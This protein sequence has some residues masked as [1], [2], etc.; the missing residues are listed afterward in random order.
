MKRGSLAGPLLIILIGVWFLVAS[1]RPDLPTLEVAARFWPFLLIGWGV[2]RLVELLL[3]V[4]KRKPLPV[5]GISGGE[6]TLVV[7]IC[8]IGSGLYVAH[9]HQPW[10][11]LPF[12]RIN[13]LEMFGQ[14]Y[15]FSIPEQRAA[16][17]KVSRILVENFRGNTRIVGGDVQEVTVAGRKSVRALSDKDAEA[18]NQQ[19]Q[20]EVTAQADQV[21]VRTNQERVTGEQRVSSDLDIT[22]PRNAAIEVRGR[23]GD[24]ELSGINGRV[25]LSSDSGDVR[26]QNLGGDVRV[27]VRKTDVLR[28]TDI[29]GKF[30]VIGGRG[31]DVELENVSGEVILNGSF[32]G[33]LQF[34]NLARGI[35]I[36]TAQTDLRVE[37]IPGSL[38]MDLG[39]MVGTNL[40]GPIRL[41]TNRSRDVRL[42][43]FTEAVEI[44]V[45]RGDIV[46]RP[47]QNK[48]PRIDVKTRVGEIELMLPAAA[49]FELKG[50]TERG[51]VFN[52]FGAPLTAENEGENGR[53]GAIT[54]RTGAGPT[55]TLNTARG[56][57]TVRK[58]DGHMPA[59]TADSDEEASEDR[60]PQRQAVRI[61]PRHGQEEIVVERH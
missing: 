29:K 61:R 18:A 20:L 55:I 49:M 3:T 5:A 21:V 40:V 33:D 43:Q 45:E 46:L 53:S 6:W 42:E 7:L 10:K 44:T 13:K 25:E 14:G 47:A 38:H 60:R 22:V 35:R 2:M 11:R 1:L 9:S 31:R 30:E 52:E 28:A 15:D 23:S 41:S 36:Q 59:V 27:D 58:D 8:L 17:T 51:E 34:R 54:G 12:V 37:K 16:A 48:L 57:I 26:L 19:T 24:L 39:D 56:N 4:S 50:A 32:S